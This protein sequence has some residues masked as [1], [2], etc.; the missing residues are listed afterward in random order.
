MQKAVNGPTPPEATSNETVDEIVALSG[1]PAVPIR[2]E[3]LQ[4]RNGDGDEVP[5]PLSEFVRTGDRRGLV[6]YLLAVTK[7]SSAPWDTALP[8][9]VWARALGMDLPQSN[10]ATS[11]ISKTWRRI[12][13]RGLIARD[14]RKRMSAV[15][16]LR[17]DR[18][19]DAY[20]HPGTDKDRHLK[21]PHAFWL[22]GPPGGRWFREL[23]LPQMA[24]LLISLSRL[25][26]FRLPF[27]SVPEWYGI[28]ADTAARGLHGLEA[29]GLVQIDKNFKKAPLAPAGYTSENRYTLQ[30]PFGPRGRRSTKGA[31]D[32]G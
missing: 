10:T 2:T 31:T 27:E 30:P 25:D 22:E 21:L 7:A 29:H 19:G 12:E 4:L 8:A 14:R 17:E 18:S 6:L 28:S 20:T 26:D 11:T 5:G 23:D 3:F 1:R 32:G 9:A 13:D 16:L 24:M 15:T